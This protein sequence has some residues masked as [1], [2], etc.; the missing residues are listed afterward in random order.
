V[1]DVD[2]E[3]PQKKSRKAS[4]DDEDFFISV[5]SSTI[6]TSSD[7]WLIDSGVSRHMT[8]YR[9]H[10]TDLV[11]KDSR[12]HVVLGDDARYTVKGFGA[13]S[14]QLDS[15][16]PLHLSDVLFVPGMRR[17]LVFISALEDKGYKVAFS[18]GKVL[19]WHKNS[20]MGSTR[21]IGVQED[22]LYT[23]TI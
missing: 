16:T 13:I 5:H 22:S 12:S 2:R 4:K 1:H 21:V 19:S 3:P 14:F 9:E 8:R 7:I 20:S 6:P 10:H 11:E 15:S 18:Y 17:N 23:V